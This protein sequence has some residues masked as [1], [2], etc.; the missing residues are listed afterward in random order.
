MHTELVAIVRVHKVGLRWIAVLFNQVHLCFKGYMSHLR[1]R[2]KIITDRCQFG[3]IQDVHLGV[4]FR[5]AVDFV[6][7]SNHADFSIF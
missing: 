3:V 4:V 6:L 5:W 7:R 1:I 2:R